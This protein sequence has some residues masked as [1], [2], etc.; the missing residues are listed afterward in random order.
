MEI[1]STRVENCSLSISI[2]AGNFSCQLR[3]ITIVVD[4]ADRQWPAALPVP[5]TLDLP[6]AKYRVYKTA[7]ARSPAPPA[8][9]RQLPDAAC[10][11]SMRHVRIG[12]PPLEI[13]ISLVEERVPD[14]ELRPSI[15]HKHRVSTLESLFDSCLSRFEIARRVVANSRYSTEMGK[16]T[17]QLAARDLRSIES[18]PGIRLRNGFATCWLRKLIRGYVTNGTC[19]QILRRNRVDLSIYS[20]VVSAIAYILKFDQPASWKLILESE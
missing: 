2:L 5:D 16:W 1:E 17:Q 12:K 6:A 18:V 15:T 4:V 14:Q 7:P 11:N 20:K 3:D 19:R 9:E 13:R 10:N 8:T